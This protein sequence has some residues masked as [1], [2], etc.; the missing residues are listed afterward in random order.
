[1]RRNLS[2]NKNIE[3]LQN[4]FESTPIIQSENFYAARIM[5]ES[6]NY[7]N[8]IIGKNYSTIPLIILSILIGLVIGVLFVLISNSINNRK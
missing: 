2:E 3:R 8:K 1:M 7:K 4:E 5:V 6:T